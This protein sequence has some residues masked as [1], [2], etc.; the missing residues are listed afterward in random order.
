MK[1]LRAIEVI[2]GML[3]VAAFLVAGS[4]QTS[5]AVKN[6]PAAKVEHINLKVSGMYCTMCSKS[7]ESSLC[8]FR[9]AKNVKA[10]Y[11][12]GMASLDVPATCKVTKTELKK[13]V[14]DAG[15]KL[16][17]VKYTTESTKPS[18]P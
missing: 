5:A 11:K 17:E 15:F 9:G 12:T 4:A 18:A 10:D 7:L 13:A 3:V 8:K 14:L 1:A 16:K 2:A 6:K